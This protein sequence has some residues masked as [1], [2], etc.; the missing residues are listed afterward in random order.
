MVPSPSPKKKAHKA[1]D[2]KVK[3]NIIERMKKGARVSS[4]VK[5]LG[6]AGSTVS[7]MWCKRDRYKGLAKTAVDAERLKVVRTRNEK[8]DKMECMLCSWVEDRVQRHQPLSQGLIC[9][10]ASSLYSSLVDE[11]QQQPS[12]SFASPSAPPATFKAIHGW[13]C[14]F[15]ER[16]GL[17]SLRIQGEAA[18]ADTVGA[19]EFPATL[20]KVVQFNGYD[21]RQFFDIEETDLYWKRMPSRCV[22]Y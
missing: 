17:H 13:F 1:L 18:A 16:A 22:K 2:L 15:K 9:D 12:T 4:S 11:Q 8:I 6:L 5:E 20:Q 19:Q 14:R 10:E 21:R 7:T 3:L